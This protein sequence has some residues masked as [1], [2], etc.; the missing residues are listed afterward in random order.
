M[1]KDDCQRSAKSNKA[2]ER[3]KFIL[4]M[5]TAVLY[6]VL[7]VCMYVWRNVTRKGRISVCIYY[8]AVLIQ[9]INFLNMCDPFLSPSFPPSV[10]LSIRLYC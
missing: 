10:S 1:D 6:T 4:E 5:C 7:Y 3:L 9:R 8:N 2:H